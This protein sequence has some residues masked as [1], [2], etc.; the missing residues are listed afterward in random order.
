MKNNSIIK[1]LVEIISN[2]YHKDTDIIKI[3]KMIS[4][5]HLRKVNTFT[6]LTIKPEGM[7]ETIHITFPLDGKNKGS[8]SIGYDKQKAK[9]QDDNSSSI[10]KKYLDELCI[11]KRN[12]IQ[13]MIS[14]SENNDK[15]QDSKEDFLKTLK[16][17]Q[18]RYANLWKKI[19]ERS[20]AEKDTIEH[21]L[22]INPKI[23]NYDEDELLKLFRDYR[24]KFYRK[25][26]GKQ[27]NKHKEEQV[28]FFV[29]VEYGKLYEL[30]G[31][32]DTHLHI[33]LKTKNQ[34]MLNKFH[35]SIEKQMKEHFG[36]RMDY[37][38]K[39]IETPNHRI[40]A[41]NYI[42]KEGQRCYTDKDFF[43]KTNGLKKQEQNPLT[44]ALYDK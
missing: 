28:K 26:F 31:K 25:Y 38:Y 43:Y 10:D 39:P 5:H 44:S 13:K 35:T 6:N 14:L 22:V 18:E 2:N 33:I 15:K 19:I 32:K 23:E 3:K 11:T 34:D 20:Y 12:G 36:E 8:F 42:Q 29:A 27:F 4:S 40:N 21:H 37:Q 41:Y 7:D 24:I 16:D 9:E 30:T 1:E 17:K